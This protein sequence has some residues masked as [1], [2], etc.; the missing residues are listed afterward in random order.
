MRW[1]LENSPLT[2]TEAMIVLKK[3]YAEHHKV[4]QE[5]IYLMT[6]HDEY[7]D[8]ALY[9]SEWEYCAEQCIQFPWLDIIF[10]EFIRNNEDKEMYI[11]Y[12]GV[13]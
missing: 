9:E 2:V 11:N 4:L 1:T 7:F 5:Q 6:T 12:G 13:R 10:E 8:S 3:D